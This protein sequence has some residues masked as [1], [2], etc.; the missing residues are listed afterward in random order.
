MYVRG[1]S[2]KKNKEISTPKVN[3][4]LTSKGRDNVELGEKDM[5]RGILLMF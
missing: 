3:I 2:I 5:G 1:E 4:V